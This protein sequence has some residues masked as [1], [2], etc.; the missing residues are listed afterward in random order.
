MTIDFES[1]LLAEVRA[2][3]ERHDAAAA[4]WRA[5]IESAVDDPDFDFDAVLGLRTVGDVAAEV[6]AAPPRRWLYRRV[7]PA[8]AYGVVGAKHKAGKSWFMLDAAVAAAAGVAWLGTFECDTPGPVLLFAG[9]G[10]APKL[11]R[12]GRAVAEARGVRWDELPILVA[13]RVPHLDDETHLAAVAAAAA[14][15]RPVLIIIDP[16]YL[17]VGATGDGRNLYSMGGVLERAQLIAQDHGAALMVAHH[18]NRNAAASGS[19]RLS[20]AGPAEWGRVLVSIEAKSHKVDTDTGRTDTHLEVVVDGD[21]VP[22]GSHRFRRVISADD[23]DDLGSR[24]RYALTAVEAAVEGSDELPGYSP[25][26]KRVLAIVSA[27]E[28]WVDVTT[29]GDRL[30]HDG[31]GPPLKRR[32]IQD[33]LATLTADG[34]VRARPRQAGGAGAWRR[35]DSGTGEDDG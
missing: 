13:E 23:Q 8:D 20:G 34:L 29:V 15:H 33:A 22:G 11:T 6:D 24:L 10:G 17:A 18:N 14:A 9:E 21:E 35:L 4:D 1:K 31:A 16:L 19:D 12:R 26:E 32:T 27:A 3:L 25:A 7:W 2:E 30:A 5:R 28:D